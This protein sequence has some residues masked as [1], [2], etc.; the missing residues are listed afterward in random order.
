MWGALPAA[1]D[2]H[3]AEFVP[4]A[5]TEDSHWGADFNVALTTIAQREKHQGEYVADVDAWLAGT[6]D[7]QTWQ[8]GELPAPIIDSLVTGTRREAPVN[9]P[10]SG[11]APDLPPDVV[12]ES[13]CV[14]DGDG[15][16]GRDRATMPAPF[17]EIVRRTV[18]VQ[19]LTVQAALSGDRDTARAAFVLDPL[20]GRG[21][22]AD[23]V[24]MADELLDATSAWLPQ[25]AAPVAG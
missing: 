4:W 25:F 21:G 8:S 7:L 15:A 1:G 12:V 18:A 22:L 13:I 10:N 23:T 14:I 11:Q 17:A 3:L 20:A 6:K 24:A 9:I 19:E 2:R 16:R 5:L